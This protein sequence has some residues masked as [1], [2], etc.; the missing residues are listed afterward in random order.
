MD[1]DLISKMGLEELKNYV[2]IRDL[3]VTGRKNELKARVFAASENGVK[4]IKTAAEVKD[5]WKTEYLPKLKIG[6]RNIS[7][8]FKILHGWMN[9]DEGMKFWV[10]LLYVALA[11]R[12]LNPIHKKGP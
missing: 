4:P 5:Y 10:M 11:L 9:K 8:P 1:Y 6:D 7:D 2:R 3:K 12:Q